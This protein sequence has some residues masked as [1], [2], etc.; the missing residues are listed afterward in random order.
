MSKG[1]IAR[2]TI[3]GRMGK[4]IEVKSL[5]KGKVG[6]FSLAVNQ[7]WGDKATTSWFN[8]VV[9]NDKKIEVLQSYTEKGSRVLVEGELRIREYTK[10]GEKKYA[11]EIVVAFDGSIE[12]IDGK[13]DGDGDAR[14][15]GSSSSRPAP[16]FD[17]ELDD[18]VPF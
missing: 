2:A 7:G 6:N 8:I 17:P 15:S 10:D 4:P 16:A 3:M 18:D 5:T 9:Y 1:T 13:K 12:I 11:T 14:A